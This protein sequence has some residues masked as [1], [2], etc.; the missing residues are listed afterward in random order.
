MQPLVDDQPEDSLHPFEA[1]TVVGVP[2]MQQ[3]RVG[4]LDVARRQPGRPAQ[5]P[6]E[7]PRPGN[8]LRVQVRS[9]FF[10]TFFPLKITRA[11]SFIPGF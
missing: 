2:L 3:D 10:G 1:R 7:L 9:P 11:G 4:H 8:R 5:P 6:G